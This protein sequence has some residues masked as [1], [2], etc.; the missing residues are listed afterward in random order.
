LGR[1]NAPGCPGVISSACHA[2]KGELCTLSVT[3]LSIF[4]V[5]AL[6][7]VKLCPIIHFFHSS[8]TVFGRLFAR[9]SISPRSGCPVRL[10]KIDRSPK[11]VSGCLRN[12]SAQGWIPP[13]SR[14]STMA[15]LPPSWAARIAAG[16]P[17]APP[18]NTTTPYISSL[19]YLSLTCVRASCSKIGLSRLAPPL[20]LAYS[21]PAC[22]FIIR[23]YRS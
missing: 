17:P 9:S 1:E 13:K 14:H 15:T 16:T 18:P 5:T 8:S 12:G 21:G 7:T 2:K 19:T 11:G 4:W 20:P 3:F 10:G 23:Q 6:I 22:R